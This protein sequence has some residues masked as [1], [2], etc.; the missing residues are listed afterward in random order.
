M[1]VAEFLRNQTLS[2]GDVDAAFK[3]A[4][5]QAKQM[6]KSRQKGSRKVQKPC[7]TMPEN[8]QN[9]VTLPPDTQ[10]DFCKVSP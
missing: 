7:S 4:N 9:C 2:L 1:L 8:S 6:P 5:Y 3:E 10:N